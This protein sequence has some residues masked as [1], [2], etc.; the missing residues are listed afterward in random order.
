MYFII[1]CGDNMSEVS[2]EHINVCEQPKVF[3][4]F[5]KGYLDPLLPQISNLS[6]FASIVKLF[7]EDV[8]WAGFYLYDGKK[9]ILGPFQGNPACVE[10]HLGSGVCGTSAKKKETV[11]VK[12]VHLFPGHI[13][14]DSASQSEIVVPIIVHGELFGVL[15]LDSPIKSRFHEIDREI[16]ESAVN[17][18]VDILS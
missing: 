4:E 9:L 6:N 10:I 1:V 13:A 16:L 18:L 14:C 8:N 5:I 2:F 12:D 11:V 15:D 7:F 17:L 3:Y